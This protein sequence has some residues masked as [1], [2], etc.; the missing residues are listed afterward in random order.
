MYAS[1]SDSLSN[2]TP[3]STGTS[4]SPSGATRMCFGGGLP[5]RF[6]RL[7]VSSRPCPATIMPDRAS[8]TI[9]VD[10]AVAVMLA[11]IWS[12]SW[13]F[14]FRGQRRSSLRGL[15]SIPTTDTKERFELPHR[16]AGPVPALA[17]LLAGLDQR[18][19]STP[20]AR[21]RL[22]LVS[23]APTG[24]DALHLA[25]SPPCDAVLEAPPS[26]AKSLHAASDDVV[27]E[28]HDSVVHL[29]VR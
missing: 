1:A 4:Q 29:C 27:A 13:S 25:P 7:S 10:E 8:S 14:R 12:R 5:L 23:A 15:Y 11:S 28:L 6:I 9:R 17:G 16:V 21:R 18:R 26:A 22:A 20:T 3:V 24:H 19:S 2:S